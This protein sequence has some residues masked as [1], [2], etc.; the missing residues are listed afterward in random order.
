[1][2]RPTE[3]PVGQVGVDSG[4]LLIIDPCY[5]GEAFYAELLEHRRS[6]GTYDLSYLTPRSIVGP[7][8]VVVS[9][10]GDGLFNVEVVS[11]SDGPC[12]VTVTL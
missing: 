3:T 6:D 10:G 12:T 5:L 1:M 4:Q 8:A 2:T 11:D 9:T 7:L